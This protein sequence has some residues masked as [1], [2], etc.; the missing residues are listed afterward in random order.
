MRINKEDFAS[1]RI[2]IH[3]KTLGWEDVTD[4][5]VSQPFIIKITIVFCFQLVR[6]KFS[7]CRSL[8]DL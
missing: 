7:L 4:T 6:V 5:T 3:E 2:A 8:K 1:K